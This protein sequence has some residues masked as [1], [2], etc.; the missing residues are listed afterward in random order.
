MD[1]KRNY[2][3]LCDFKRILSEIMWFQTDF[4]RIYANIC[5]SKRILSETMLLKWIL[6]EIMRM[7]AFL[8]GF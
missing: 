4:K 7:Y 6:S 2:A 1:F 8:S 5:D 3:N